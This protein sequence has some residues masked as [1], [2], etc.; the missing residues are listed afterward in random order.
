MELK[1]KKA[2]IDIRYILLLIEPLLELKHSLGYH[3]EGNFYAF[4]RTT[5][6]IETFYNAVL[7][8]APNAFNRTTFGIETTK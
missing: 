8:Q 7:I 6:G 1:P 5:F 2:K 3:S 4:N